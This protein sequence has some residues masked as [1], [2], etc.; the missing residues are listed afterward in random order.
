MDRDDGRG[1]VMDYGDSDMGGGNGD[2]SGGNGDMGDS[3]G[4]MGDGDM[5]GGDVQVGYFLLMKAMVPSRCSGLML[6]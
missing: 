1:G 6:R 4:D 5:G 2:M 3:N